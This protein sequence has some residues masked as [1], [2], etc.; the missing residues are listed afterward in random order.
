[1]LTPTQIGEI[2]ERHVVAALRQNNHANIKVNTRA[3]GSTD[4]E[5][6]SILVQVKTSLGGV[7]AYPS[8]DEIRNLKSRAAKL[9]K[10]AYVAQ[11][12]INQDGSLAKAIDWSKP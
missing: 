9:G 10:E 12:V 4:I 3:P 11:V 7:P 8:S 2:G 5:T 1:M 6:N